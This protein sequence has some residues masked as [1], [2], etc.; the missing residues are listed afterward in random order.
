M[1][2]IR[3][4]AMGVVALALVACGSSTPSA[5][6]DTSSGGA[7]SP[8]TQSADQLT[9]LMVSGSVSGGDPFFQAINAGMAQAAKDLGV[10]AEWIGPQNYDNL[11]ADMA[12]LIQIAINRNP[13][14]LAVGDFVPDAE[15]PVIAQAVQAGIPVVI[16]NSGV[17][18]WRKVGAL[19]FVGENSTE[20][21]RAAAREMLNKG[22]QHGL[23]VNHVPQ[24][25]ATQARCVGFTE[26]MEAEGTQASTLNIP[27]SQAGDP[28]AIAS[29]IRG[30]LTANADIDGVYTLGAGAA[31][32]AL[33]AVEDAGKTD[34]VKVGTSD[35]S[36]NVLE[37]VK[38]GKLI[39]AID[40]QPYLQGYYSVL[41]LVQN[42][43]YGLAPSLEV[44]TG[45]LVLTPDN[46]QKVYDVQKANPGVRGAG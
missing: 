5:A 24:N 38:D 3:Q 14:G 29:A 39:F 15:D 42:I 6:T 28:T 1:F 23:C 32:S 36:T 26:V 44:W 46:V 12:N 40:Q 17:D 9:I 30:Q 10:N 13:S 18:S 4:L 33:R 19:G 34:T 7:A 45:P 16:Q 11:A 43:R 37:A 2:G 22:G 8:V 31:E 41:M 20:V 25:P 27:S 21:G 35:L